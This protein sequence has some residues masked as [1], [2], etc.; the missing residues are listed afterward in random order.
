MK[1]FERRGIFDVPLAKGYLNPLQFLPRSE[2]TKQSRN[3]RV[4]L[5]CSSKIG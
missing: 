2:A 4:A 3:A 1:R 5:N